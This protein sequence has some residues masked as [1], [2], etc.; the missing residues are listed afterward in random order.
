MDLHHA[1]LEWHH[2]P[3]WGLNMAICFLN[4][5]IPKR[6]FTCPFFSHFGKFL[7]QK[8]RQCGVNQSSLFYLKSHH[9]LVLCL[10]FNFSRE[11]DNVT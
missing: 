2:V 5:F 10:F 8:K 1:L 7:P 9:F 11:F 6:A 3:H 4:P